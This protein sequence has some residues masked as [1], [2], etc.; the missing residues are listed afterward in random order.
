[1]Q[2]RCFFWKKQP[3]LRCFCVCRHCILNQNRGQ[4][5]QNVR[6]TNGWAKL[7]EITLQSFSTVLFS[8]LSSSALNILFCFCPPPPFP[9]LPVTVLVQ[10]LQNSGG[11]VVPA[12]QAPDKTT[13]LN[14]LSAVKIKQKIPKLLTTIMTSKQPKAL[15]TFNGWKRKNLRENN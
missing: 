8:F 3:G 6:T 15:T 5:M 13:I 10:W 7:S 9:F 4:T 11:E 12:G 2:W 1:M 14:L